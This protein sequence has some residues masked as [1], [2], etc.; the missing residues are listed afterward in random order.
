MKL[1]ALSLLALAS[2][3]SLGGAQATGPLQDSEESWTLVN[4]VAIQ[5]GNRLVTLGE[6][7]RILKAEAARNQIARTDPRYNQLAA[8]IVREYAE[9]QLEPQAGE[10]LGMDPAQVE[11]VVSRNLEDQRRDRGSS[12][13]AELLDQQGQTL[14]EVRDAQVN[15]TWRDIWRMT[16]TGSRALPERPI[17]DSFVRP[18]ELRSIYRENKDA[19][20]PDI[21]ELQLLGAPVRSYGGEEGGRAFLEELRQRALDGEDFGMLVEQNGEI[22]RDRQ[23]L[24]DPVPVPQLAEPLRS[25]AAGAAQGEVGPVL[26]FEL[27]EPVLLIPYVFRKVDNEPPPFDDELTQAGLRERFRSIRE[28]DI[29]RTGRQRLKRKAFVWYTPRLRGVAPGQTGGTP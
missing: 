29:L 23:G 2:L 25:F 13:F 8:Q 24:L 16:E 28:E 7:D 22:Q 5:A 26:L 1:L 15:Q 19:L 6:L 20:E 3:P 12:G 17:R 27:G 11:L 9:L 18:G 21:V 10:D 14:Q 4:G